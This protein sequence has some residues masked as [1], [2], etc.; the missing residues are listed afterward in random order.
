MMITHSHFL[1]CRASSL[2]SL[3]GKSLFI[4]T[5]KNH[6]LFAYGEY[7][8]SENLPPNLRDSLAELL[9]LANDM[10]TQVPETAEC[11]CKERDAD[12]AEAERYAEYASD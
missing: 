3:T 7:K 5:W 2:A 12:D 9:I 4:K 8:R 6:L 10:D 1:L 11:A